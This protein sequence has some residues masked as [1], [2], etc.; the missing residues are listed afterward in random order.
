MAPLILRNI[1]PQV[2]RSNA[3]PDGKSR[4]EGSKF[5]VQK[6]ST[7]LRNTVK[8][9]ESI[10]IQINSIIYTPRYYFLARARHADLASLDPIERAKEKR[11]RGGRPK[12]RPG[13]KQT[14][15]VY[16]TLPT[17]YVS[18]FDKLSKLA[19]DNLV[20]DALK[21]REVDT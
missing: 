10:S 14:K 3:V 11:R 15:R 4:F 12:E 5:F 13:L 9:I 1:T 17:E 8:C 6:T 21:R 20:L 18:Q 16:F 2:P 19:R 7:L